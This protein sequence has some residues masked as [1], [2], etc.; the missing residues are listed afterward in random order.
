VVA[1]PIGDHQ[2]PAR[3]LAY[4]LGGRQASVA[5]DE[6]DHAIDAAFGVTGDLGRVRPGLGKYRCSEGHTDEHDHRTGYDS[7]QDER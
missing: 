5:A 3:L 4:C 2:C 6:D 7:E 1:W